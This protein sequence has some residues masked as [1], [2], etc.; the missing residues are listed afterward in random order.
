MPRDANGEEGNPGTKLRSSGRSMIRTASLLVLELLVCLVVDLGATLWLVSLVIRSKAFSYALL[1]LVAA[2]LLFLTLSYFCLVR[3]GKAAGE[4]VVMT[5]CF[6]AVGTVLLVAEVLLA[7]ASALEACR[8]LPSAVE[9]RLAHCSY[10]ALHQA[11]RD[12]AADS[13]GAIDEAVRRDRRNPA[14]LEERG[15]LGVEL[16]DLLASGEA[17]SASAGG[18]LALGPDD[19]VKRAVSDYS[20]AL[21]L[22]QGED[23]EAAARKARWRAARAMPRR[24]LSGSVARR[25][26]TRLPSRPRRMMRFARAAGTGAEGPTPNWVTGA[27]RWAATSGP[28][29]WRTTGCTLTR[30]TRPVRG[31][32]DRFG[33]TPSGGSVG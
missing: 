19:C 14:Y 23:P 27:A 10:Y 12:R 9:G 16:H 33:A 25:R 1:A 7:V 3:V 17:P 5:A 6:R 29:D 28:A 31:S 30:E 22:V 4:G 15:D 32:A 2:F 26:T 11:F 20:S 24:P 8:L 21:L 13:L 18:E